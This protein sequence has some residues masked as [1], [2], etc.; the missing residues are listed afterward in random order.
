MNSV[1]RIY[2]NILVS[3]ILYGS[4]ARGDDTDESDI[5]VAVILKPGESRKMFEALT[6]DMVDLE[7]A[8]DKLVSIVRID[9]EKFN[10]WSDVMPFYRNIKKDGI[11]LWTDA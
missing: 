8:C 6:D 9:S 11:V 5:D 4:T 2:G 10:E 7:L 3:V 1:E